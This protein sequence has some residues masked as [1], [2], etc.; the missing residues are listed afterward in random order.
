MYLNHS[1]N[2]KLILTKKLKSKKVIGALKFAS[3]WVEGGYKISYLTGNLKTV[4]NIKIYQSKWV[5]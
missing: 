2:K 3:F 1:H 5:F 4:I